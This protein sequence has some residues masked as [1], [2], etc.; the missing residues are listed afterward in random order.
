MSTHFFKS[1]FN[2]HLFIK[3]QSAIFLVILIIIS[4]FKDLGSILSCLQDHFAFISYVP[5]SDYICIAT[6]N[7]ERE[8]YFV[9]SLFSIVLQRKVN[10]FRYDSTSDKMHF[11]F[12]FIWQT[13][14]QGRRTRNNCNIILK[15]CFFFLRNLYPVH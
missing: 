6:L 1:I 15:I 7:L 3:L 4:I 11:I 8:I 12:N 14:C 2:H 13:N 5:C 10:S 9:W